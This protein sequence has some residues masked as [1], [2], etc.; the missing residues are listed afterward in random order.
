MVY[1]RYSGGQPLASLAA[2]PL[3]SRDVLERKGRD[4]VLVLFEDSTEEWESL[5]EE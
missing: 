5:L 2:V 1:I 3:T 4:K